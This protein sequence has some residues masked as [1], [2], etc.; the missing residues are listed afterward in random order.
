MANATLVAEE[1]ADLPG[2]DRV[3]ILRSLDYTADGTLLFGGLLPGAGSLV[4]TVTPPRPAGTAART[5]A[6]ARIQAGA[7]AVAPLLAIGQPLDRPDRR[8][9]AVLGRFVAL[10]ADRQ[11]LVARFSLRDGT[12]GEGLFS[13]ARN[14]QVQAIA[15]TGD[16][17]A[18][19][20]GARFAGFGD[21]SGYTLNPPAVSLSSKRRQRVSRST[22]P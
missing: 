20:A 22:L 11:L 5:A 13:L 14:G 15:V 8:L 19:P 7:P 12:V 18:V 21:T 1:G 17:A 2:A 4:A 16:A 3:A 10:G 6:V 9:L